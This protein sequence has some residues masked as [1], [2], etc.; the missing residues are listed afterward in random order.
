[1]MSMVNNASMPVEVDAQASYRFPDSG[2]HSGRCSLQRSQNL[3]SLMPPVLQ[4]LFDGLDY[5]CLW[6]ELFQGNVRHQGWRAD[7]GR[8]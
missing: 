2:H 5:V 1:M 3:N 8:Y 6:L 7:H 4:Q